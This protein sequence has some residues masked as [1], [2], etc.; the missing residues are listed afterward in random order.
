MRRKKLAAHFRE[1]F[2]NEPSTVTR[3]NVG[4][5]RKRKMKIAI[6]LAKARKS[7]MNIPKA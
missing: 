6:A 4:K 1:V 5:K 2:E 7:G 3:A